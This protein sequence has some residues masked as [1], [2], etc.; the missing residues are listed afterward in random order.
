MSTRST[1][2]SRTSFL[3]RLINLSTQEY[4]LF[5]GLPFRSRLIAAL[6]LACLYLTLLV[7]LYL[8]YR[9]TL[10]ATPGATVAVFGLIAF[11]APVLLFSLAPLLY[12]PL[13][14]YRGA[15]TAVLLLLGLAFG[16]ALARYQAA[17][18]LPN[19][20]PDGV[21]LLGMGLGFVLLL[22]GIHLYGRVMKRVTE[23]K[24]HMENEMLLA[25]AIHHRLL[26]DIAVEAPRYRVYGTSRTASDVGGD[27]FD[28]A[29]LPDGRLMVAIGDVAGHNVA[30]GLLAAIAKGAFRTALDQGLAPDVLLAS[31]NRS[32]YDLTERRMFV[33]FQCGLFDFSQGQLTLANAGHPPLLHYRR[34]TSEIAEVRP[35]GLALGMT[36]QASFGL[37]EVAFEAGDVFLF[38][39]DGLLEA[40][41]EAREEFGL[42]RTKALFA[43][44]DGS[45]PEALSQ[46]LWRALDAFTGG[47]LP[48]D[49]IT[50][51]VVQV[52]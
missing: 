39:T 28:A 5:F 50:T 47:G 27:L 4:D 31:L 26:P 22:T 33:S 21:S 38:C 1:F 29:P 6:A 20:E 52:G 36:R 17:H 19:A 14:Q 48:T 44:T 13:W 32:L 46:R 2:Q 16:Y 45:A 11:L 51:L 43:Q 8:A 23:E 10:L 25:Q 37:T 24:T 34:R 40:F 49:N 35:Q 41:S 7:M 30:A 9:P 15:F 3:R 42:E 18:G 12:P